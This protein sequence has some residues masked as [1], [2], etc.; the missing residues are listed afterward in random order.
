MKGGLSSG[1]DSP[2]V[3]CECGARCYGDSINDAV[4][5]WARHVTTAHSSED[6]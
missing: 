1:G 4:L 6:W 5:S 3:E 2:L